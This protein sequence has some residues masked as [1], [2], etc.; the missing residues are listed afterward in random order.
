[1]HKRAHD[2]ALHEW[3]GDVLTVRN[4]R[5][6]SETLGISGACDVVEFHKDPEGISV[7]GLPE[8][9]RIYPVEYKKGRPKEGL[10]DCLQLCA[11]AMCLEEMLCCD[12]PEGALYYGETHRRQTVAFEQELR[13]KVRALLEEMH[14]YMKRGHTPKVKPSKACNACSLK[15]ICLPKLMRKKSAAA[16]VREELGGSL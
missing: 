8:K 1:M 7:N 10:E 2:A 5:I 11:Q 4:I 9:Y 15:D 6:A 16:Y 13:M 12:I 3:R 14:Q